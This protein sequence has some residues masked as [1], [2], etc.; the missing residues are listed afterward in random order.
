MSR[1]L[2]PTARLAPLIWLHSKEQYYPS[3][4]GAQLSK[5][6]PQSKF[7]AV[8]GAQSP[9][10]LDNLATLN[11]IAGTDV[12]L[13]S[14]DDVTRNPAWLKGVK[15]DSSGRTPG[16]ISA[17][18]IVNDKGNGNTD[19]FYMYF[20][21]FNE[22]PTYFGQEVGDHVGDW[23]HNM[24]RFKDGKPQSLWY[25]QHAYGQA[26]T[27]NAVEKQGIRPIGYSAKGSHAVYA[28]AG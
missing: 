20:Y 3:D 24:I 11:N 18:I 26:F 8:Q 1:F 14:V 19:V 4:I 12:W 28:I 23:E 15:P 10:T 17:A 5:T 21:A 13:T 9:L 22:G 25:S 6:Q 2:L 7:A 27:Y 16:A